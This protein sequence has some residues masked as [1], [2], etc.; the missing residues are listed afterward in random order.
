MREH[1]CPYRVVNSDHMQ[2]SFEAK[3]FVLFM[4]VVLLFGADKNVLETFFLPVRRNRWLIKDFFE[5]PRLL[6]NHVP[7][8]H[9]NL[10]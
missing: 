9:E 4:I 5:R 3:Y 6:L 1:D 7:V 2:I 8:F 10:F